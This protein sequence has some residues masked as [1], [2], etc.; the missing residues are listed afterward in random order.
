M[1]SFA[2]IIARWPSATALAEDLKA[3]GL[4]VPPVTVRSWRGNGIPGPYWDHVC[5]AAKE[6]GFDGVTRDLLCR[7]GA[8]ASDRI[9]GTHG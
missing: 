8:A 7:L 9:G 3:R 5:E 4:M 2:E 6:R 1:E